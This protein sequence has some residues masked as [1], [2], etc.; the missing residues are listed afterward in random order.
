LLEPLWQQFAALL[1]ERP[2]VSPTHPLGCHRRRIPDR[3]VF[4]HVIAALI[5]GSGYERI[6]QFSDSVEV[7][8]IEIESPAKTWFNQ[9]GTQTADFTHAQDQLHK[10]QAW[11][12][13]P[14][15]IL[16][17]RTMY[18]IERPP[19]SHRA[20]R[21]HYMLIYGSSRRGIGGRPLDNAKRT[22]MRRPDETYMTFARLA[23]SA[24]STEYMTVRIQGGEYRAI[25][26]PPTLRLSPALAAVRAE[27]VDNE[28]AADTC[29]WATPERRAFLKR[30]FGYWDNW[31]RQG[32]NF[33][34]SGDF[35]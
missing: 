15:H 6:A 20:F 25:S 35:E 5:H 7:V 34:N 11:F 18:R 28:D 17:F 21:Q 22:Q 12:S 32:G 19:Q 3:V 27:I 2:I 26:L 10:W 4:E 9:D 33:W 8:L 30:R 13:E 23:P 16:L 24:D 29:A 31:T 14:E 1:P